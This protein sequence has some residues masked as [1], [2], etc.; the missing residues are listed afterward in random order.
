MTTSSFVIW[1]TAA[2]VTAAT[3]LTWGVVIPALL[4]DAFINPPA[5]RCSCQGRHG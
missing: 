5:S 4:L 1:I 2:I 3:G